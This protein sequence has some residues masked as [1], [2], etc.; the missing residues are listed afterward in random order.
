MGREDPP[1]PCLTAKGELIAAVFLAVKRRTS[2]PAAAVRA[3]RGGSLG[4]GATAPG[5]TKV[6][7]LA[8][9]FQRQEI[10]QRKKILNNAPAT[11]I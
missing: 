4:F 5:F 10:F 3:G 8:Q 2:A 1:R 7:V 6:I 11:Q 9:V